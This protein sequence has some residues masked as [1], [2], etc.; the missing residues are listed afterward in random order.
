MTTVNNGGQTSYYDV[1][2][3]AKTLN[4]LIEYK[5]MPPWQHEIFKACYALPERGSKI[6]PEN[7]LKGMLREIN[8]MEYY[9]NRGKKLIEKELLSKES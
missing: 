3:N 8:K 5:N 7:P 2:K 6:N 9:L 1:P 4:D